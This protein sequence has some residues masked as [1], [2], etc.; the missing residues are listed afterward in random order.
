MES[1]WTAVWLPILVAI[2]TGLTV[3]AVLMSGYGPWI[4]QRP[5]VR[6]LEIQEKAWYFYYRTTDNAN[7]HIEGK[8]LWVRIVVK[9][10]GL[11]KSFI[12]AEFTDE[13]GQVFRSGGVIHLEPSE[14]LESN[15]RMRSP[16]QKGSPEEAKSLVGTL[17]LEPSGN[18]RMFFGA[19]W[20]KEQIEVPYDQSKLLE[21]AWGS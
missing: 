17:T 20:L 3:G 11:E 5:K 9:N 21:T 10:D 2:F 13:H 16:R 6:I 15:I 14:R 8:E 18:R 19:K 7:S 1:D 12:A 4:S